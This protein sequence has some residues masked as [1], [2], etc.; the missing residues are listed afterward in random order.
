MLLNLTKQ[1]MLKR[2]RLVDGL[3]PSSS[4]AAIERTDGISLDAMLLEDLRL[5]YMNLLDTADPQHL[6]CR[7]VKA[8]CTASIVAPA[9]AIAVTFPAA[10]RRPVSIRIRGWQRSAMILGHEHY[11][12]VLRRQFNPYTAAAAGSPVAVTVPRARPD[13]PHQVLVWPKIA[14]NFI[15]EATAII[16]PGP[17][18]YILDES[19][20]PW[21]MH[22]SW[23]MI[24]D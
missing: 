1:E 2:R 21:R 10:A 24:H 13:T 8:E 11:D 15:D 23:F 4:L 17:E 12:A 9:A 5:W 22:D 6:P 19:L 3:E 16:D 18:S 14:G 20:L 7:D